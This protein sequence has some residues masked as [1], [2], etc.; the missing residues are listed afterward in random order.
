M[1]K[2]YYDVRMNIQNRPSVSNRTL[3]IIY[4]V[5]NEE[6]VAMG[7][8]I[9]KLMM[10]PTLWGEHLNRIAKYDKSILI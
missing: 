9:E 4:E 10:S 8:A 5:M 1:Q 6:G 7:V 3:K 2:N